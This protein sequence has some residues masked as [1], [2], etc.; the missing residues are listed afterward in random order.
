MLTDLQRWNRCLTM[1]GVINGEQESA[2]TLA[3]KL[4]QVF[5]Q[6]LLGERRATYEAF[7]HY[8]DNDYFTEANMFTQSQHYNSELG[9]TMPLALA[10]ALQFIIVIFSRDPATPTMYITPEVVTTEATAFLV[11]NSTGQG[12]YDAAVPHHKP[13]QQNQPRSTN[14]RCG[15]NDKTSTQQSCKPSSIYTT[16]CK[17]YKDS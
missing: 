6:E 13:N 17:C 4:R 9:D 3:A 2:Q 16:R 1:A 7:V 15:V 14:C 8:T 11:Y 5:V 10:T 12:H